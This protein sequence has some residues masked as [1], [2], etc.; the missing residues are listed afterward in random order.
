MQ[1]IPV[2]YSTPC[3]IGL[4]SA[5]SAAFFVKRSKERQ[6]SATDMFDPWRGDEARQSGAVPAKVRSGFAFGT[7]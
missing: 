3:N 4:I 5:A 7:T 6:T 2:P 1:A